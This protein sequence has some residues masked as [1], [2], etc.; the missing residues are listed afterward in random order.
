MEQIIRSASPC[1][2]WCLRLRMAW[3]PVR[4]LDGLQLV[5]A[6]HWA[7]MHVEDRH[8][9][10]RRREKATHRTRSVAGVRGTEYSGRFLFVILLGI[11]RRP[12]LSQDV[13]LGTSQIYIAFLIPPQYLFCSIHIFFS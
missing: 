6:G 10:G 1:P 4:S 2:A 12:S 11:Y 7:S 9:I 5:L 13:Q 8:C 3:A